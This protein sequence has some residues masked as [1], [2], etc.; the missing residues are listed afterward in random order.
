MIYLKDFFSIIPLS[1]GAWYVLFWL[2]IKFTI[3]LPVELSTNISSKSESIIWISAILKSLFRR[4]IIIVSFV[5]SILIT[6]I[7]VVD[8]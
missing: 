2:E 5:F 3:Y 7:K 4:E 1:S 8:I 6:H